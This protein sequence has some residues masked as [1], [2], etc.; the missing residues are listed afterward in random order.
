MLNCTDHAL[1]ETAC[2]QAEMDCARHTHQKEHKILFCLLVRFPSFLYAGSL[3]QTQV[4]HESHLPSA[5]FL[6]K[7]WK[8]PGLRYKFVSERV[9]KGGREISRENGDSRSRKKDLVNQ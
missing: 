6:D 2:L 9:E 4:R 5:L 7:K 1:D 8:K 3:F